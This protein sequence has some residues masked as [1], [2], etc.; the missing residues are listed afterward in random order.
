MLH[1]EEGG[2]C[3]EDAEWDDDLCGD[4]DGCVNCYPN[5]RCG[6]DDPQLDASETLVFG[7]ACIEGL[8]DACYGCSPCFSHDIGLCQ[9]DGTMTDAPAA[10]DGCTSAC[11]PC[12][13]C[14]PYSRCGGG[15]VPTAQPVS[16]GGGAE[17]QQDVV[18]GD[19]TVSGVTVEEAQANEAVFVAAIAYVTMVPA[20]RISAGRP[21]GNPN[22]L[23]CPSRGRHPTPQKRSKTANSSWL[24][25]LSFERTPPSAAKTIKNGEPVGPG[26]ALSFE[27]T[28]PAVQRRKNDRKTDFFARRST[29]R[30]P[31]DVD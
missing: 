5:S 13:A 7:D 22:P 2:L 1:V 21:S 18:V 23:L 14:Y 27:R 28:P 11:Q 20:D 8:F 31:S 17:Q 25:A 12:I 19:M 15:L 30:R 9:D 6:E 24:F 26:V 3:D 16:S 29:S 4:C 10:E